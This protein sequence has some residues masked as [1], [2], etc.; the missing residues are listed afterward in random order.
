MKKKTK[1]LAKRA[2]CIGLAAVCSALVM[3]SSPEVVTK[4]S[5]SN[6]SVQKYEDEIAAL[7]Q[8]QKDLQAQIDSIDSEAAAT[9]QQKQYYDSMA[10]TVQ[11]KITATEALIEELNTEIKSTEDAI[12]ELE[13]SIAKTTDKIKER[14]LI[15]QQ[16]GTAGYLELVLGA[17]DIGEFLSQFERVGMMIEYDNETLDKYKSQKDDLENAKKSLKSSIEL[18]NDTIA[19]LEIDKQNSQYW[20]AQ[21]EQYLQT[22]ENDKASYQA[23]YEKAKAQEA[24]LDN[25]LS[26]LL[27]QIQQQNSSQVIATDGDWCWPIQGGGYVSCYY[28]DS[29]PNGAPHYAVDTAIAAGTPIY[30]ANDGYVLRAEWHYSYGNYIVLDHGNG[31]STLYAHCSGL[32]VGAGQSVVK[33]QVIGYVGSSGFSTGNHLHFEFRVGGQKVNPMSYIPH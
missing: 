8:R 5:A 22:L 23:E 29:D 17:E 9:L 28:G 2:L 24:A 33:G 1:K 12:A 14:M 30:A 32:A 3:Y 16:T 25:E 31:L 10:T 18:Q 7:E 15:N 21:S 20:S 11:A 6:A 26:A 4:V 13:K 19:Q 27:A